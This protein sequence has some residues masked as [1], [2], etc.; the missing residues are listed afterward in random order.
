[1][2]NWEIGSLVWFKL[3][4]LPICE[5]QETLHGLGPFVFCLVRI[6]TFGVAASISIG[7]PSFT[8]VLSGSS[9]ISC[10]TDVQP[11]APSNLRYVATLLCRSSDET[12]CLST[13]ESSVVYSPLASQL[14]NGCNSRS[15]PLLRNVIIAPFSRSRYTNG[16]HV[17]WNNYGSYVG[18]QRRRRR[19]LDRKRDE[20]FGR[21]RRRKSEKR[22]G[23]TCNVDRPSWPRTLFNF[24]HSLILAYLALWLF[25]ILLPLSSRMS[26]EKVLGAPFRLS[27]PTN[28]STSLISLCILVLSFLVSS[29]LSFSRW[30]DASVSFEVSSTP[31]E[32]CLHVSLT[33]FI[34]LVFAM[35]TVGRGSGLSP[36][37]KSRRTN[38]FVLRCS[39]VTLLLARDDVYV[40]S[41]SD[42]SSTTI[43]ASSFCSESVSRWQK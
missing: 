16:A 41:S 11:S 19:W 25:V 3:E 43:P 21:R 17:G 31:S 29:S 32:T 22:N 8:G 40:H 23:L 1:M 36:S 24:N 10:D 13:S 30:E 26:W 7:W 18:Q 39:L 28:F 38:T 12:D 4:L 5:M 34:S 6:T 37:P 33:G 15:L 42:E 2:E 14:S 20:D 27:S 35:S 9:N